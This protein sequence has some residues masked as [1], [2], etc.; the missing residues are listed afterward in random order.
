MES[1]DSRTRF[2]RGGLLIG[3]CLVLGFLGLW[4]LSRFWKLTEKYTELSFQGIKRL[5]ESTAADEAIVVLTGGEHRIPRAIELLKLRLSPLLIIS[6]TGKNIT[7]KDLAN[8]QGDAIFNIQDVWSR[9]LLEP[10]SGSTVE[11]AEES[12]NLLA[13]RSMKRVILVTSDYHCP[14]ALALFKKILPQYEY[15]IYP[16]ASLQEFSLEAL[17]HWWVEYWKFLTFRIVDKIGF[18]ISAMR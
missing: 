2:K 14:R 11:N 15:W 13:A 12:G 17:G 5:P 3:V 4:D 18:R 10:R 9:I 1:W 16:V 7:L 8:N 6:G